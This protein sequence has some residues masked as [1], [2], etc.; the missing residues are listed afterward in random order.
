MLN[1]N[2][3]CLVKDHTVIFSICHHLQQLVENHLT[4]CLVSIGVDCP[5]APSI[6]VSFFDC[7]LLKDMMYKELSMQDNEVLPYHNVCKFDL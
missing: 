7:M 4:F 5:K 3:H 6:L 1:L 2:I